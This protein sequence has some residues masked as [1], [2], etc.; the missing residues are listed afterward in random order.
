[1]NL[2]YIF[3]YIQNICQNISDILEVDVTLVSKDM[4]RIAGTGI[5]KDRIGEQIPKESV[6]N[7]ILQNGK[8]YK[9]DRKYEYMCRKCCH[10][11]T[12]KE[13]A[14][15]CTPVM[16]NDEILGVLGIA[17]IDEVRKDII[18]SKEREIIALIENMSSLI[19]FKLDELYKRQ[20]KTI[21]ILEKEEIEKAIKEYGTSTESMKKIADALDIGIATLYR[22]IKKFNIK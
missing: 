8:T 14:D 21:E 9:I 16:K 12:C 13:L 17:V 7:K 15:I 18:F 4:K 6:Y 2:N 5:F 22:K 3:E 19:S 11:E 10:N 20:I 1:M